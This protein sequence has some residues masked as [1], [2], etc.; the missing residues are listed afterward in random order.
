MDEEADIG[1]DQNTFKTGQSMWDSWIQ[2]L[3]S[4]LCKK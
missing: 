3:A 2:A 4:K 1:L